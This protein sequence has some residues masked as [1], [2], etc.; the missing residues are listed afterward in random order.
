MAAGG[1][2]VRRGFCVEGGR[3]VGGLGRWTRLCVYGDRPHQYTL[4]SLNG[5]HPSFF[6]GGCDSSTFGAKA[7]SNFP[8]GASD[9]NF[10]VFGGALGGREVG[11]QLG[12]LGWF[13]SGWREGG[14]SS[15]LVN[16]AARALK[17]HGLWLCLVVQNSSEICTNL[18]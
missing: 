6:R 15:K 16:L 14:L 12:E 4:S 8:G 7:T 3:R 9:L 18:G 2:G 1:A 5:G 11:C 10:F 13:G 17:N